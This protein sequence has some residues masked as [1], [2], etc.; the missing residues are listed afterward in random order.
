MAAAERGFAWTGL[1][2]AHGLAL[3]SAARDTLH[4]EQETIKRQIAECKLLLATLM[5]ADDE[6]RGRLEEANDQ[7]GYMVAAI[8]E[9]GLE[10]RFRREDYRPA[11]YLLLSDM[12]SDGL[13]PS[14]D[15]DPE[16][17]YLSESESDE[18]GSDC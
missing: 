8:N 13:A 9:E 4:A 18:G 16:P 14:S 7:V 2:A 11:S 15:A 12:R 17:N 1:D 6:A 10:I 3:A 5:D